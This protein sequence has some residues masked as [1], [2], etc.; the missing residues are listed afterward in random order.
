MRHSSLGPVMIHLSVPDD[1]NMTETKFIQMKALLITAE[2]IIQMMALPT[3][4]ET[5]LVASSGCQTKV[6]SKSILWPETF[7]P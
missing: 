4:A 6:Y 3:T 5:P 7:P 2:P 1:K